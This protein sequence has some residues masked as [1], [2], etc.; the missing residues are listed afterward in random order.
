MM[1][2]ERS[3]HAISSSIPLSRLLLRGRFTF[4]RNRGAITPTLLH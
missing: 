2:H 3:S 1:L 4:K